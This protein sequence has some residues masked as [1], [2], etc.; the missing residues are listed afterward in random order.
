MVVR[1]LLGEGMVNGTV[2]SAEEQL[3]RKDHVKDFLLAQLQ[4]ELW[5]SH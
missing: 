4:Q 1:K 5:R 2:A 3:F